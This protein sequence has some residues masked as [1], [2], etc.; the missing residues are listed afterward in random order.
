MSLSRSL[1]LAPLLA[2]LALTGC[3]M[4]NGSSSAPV[5]PENP[6][7]ARIAALQSENAQLKDSLS[8]TQAE[9][10][11]A[12]SDKSLGKALGKE[13][14]KGDAIE[15]TTVTEGG[16]L[17]LSEDFA[18]AKGS[19]DL[20][21]D[22]KKTIEKIAARLNEG[23]NANAKVF[24]EGHTDDTPVAR[25]ATKEKYGDN[26][27]LSAARSASVIRALEAA[28]VEPKRLIGRFRGEHAPRAT[29]AADKAKNRRVEIFLGE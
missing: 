9:L 16:G 10:E 15:G 17:A 5:N 28:H 23:E 13:L 4:R 6:D 14:G 7:T 2:S 20:N 8:A 29:D 1:L 22:G 25:H 27:G 12:K 19:A 18:F 11:K 21:D 24:V 3:Q 26:W